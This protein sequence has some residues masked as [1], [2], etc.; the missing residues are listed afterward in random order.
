MRRLGA[1]DTDPSVYLCVGFFFAVVLGKRVQ[2]QVELVWGIIS[3]LAGGNPLLAGACL[4]VCSMAALAWTL[5]ASTVSSRGVKQQAVRAHRASVALELAEGFWSWP[6]SAE[7][8][9][10][11]GM[12]SRLV[13]GAGVH[14]SSWARGCWR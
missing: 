1:G 2:G 14:D 3:V 7:P 12:V 6:F 8:L 11:V 9:M 13:R 5:T 4:R 10:R